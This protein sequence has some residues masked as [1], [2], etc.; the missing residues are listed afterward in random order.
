ME[1]Q[2]K[3]VLTILASVEAQ[4]K[5]IYG[6]TYKQAV[7]ISDVRKAIESGDATFSWSRNPGA[8]KKLETL[9]S[10]M[11][12]K[13]RTLIAKA[14][15]EAEQK[16]E[17]AA[18]GQL[19][20]AF[21]N[22]DDIKEL[23]REAIDL[24]RTVASA[25]RTGLNKSRGGFSPSSNVW[26][27]DEQSRKE[28]EAIIQKGIMEGKSADEVSRSI[29]QYLNEPDKLFRRVRDPE[30]GE[31]RL[32]KAASEYHPGP[33][34]YRSAYK[35]AMRLAR[36]E[37]TAAYRQS[38]W[39]SW[40]NNPLVVGIEIRLSNN[41]T[42]EDSKTGER[43]T[44]YDVCDEL[45][46]VYPKT[47]RWTGWH[48]QCRCDLYPVLV[49]K[50]DVKDIIKKRREARHAGKDPKE[51]LKDWHSKREVDNMPD[52]F[53]DWIRRN[54]DRLAQHVA[55]GKTPPYWVTD[56]FNSADIMRGLAKKLVQ[57]AAAAQPG[58]VPDE[59]KQDLEA[60]AKKIGVEV[61]EPMTFEEADELR[62]NPNY[63]SGGGYRVNC[64]SCVV[65]NELRRRGLDVEAQRNTKRS[66]NIPYELS[67]KTEWAWIDPKTGGRPTKTTCHATPDGQRTGQRTV[68]NLIKNVEEA[69]KNPGRY[70]LDWVWRG[71][72]SG[73]IITA[74]RLT[75]GTLRFYDPQ[76]GKLF[77]FRN[78]AS[79][80]DLYEG[81][82][83]L[84]VDNLKI[85]TSI[86][87]GVV[88]KSGKTKPTVKRMKSPEDIKFNLFLKSYKRMM[89]WYS[90]EDKVFDYWRKQGISDEFIAEF[91]E[92]LA[93][94]SSRTRRG[95]VSGDII[96]E[97]KQ[98][99]AEVLK[100]SR[101]KI[102]GKITY[103]N[104]AFGGKVAIFSRN[105]VTENLRLGPLFYVKTEILSEIESYLTPELKFKF[106][107]ST[108]GNNLGFYKARTEYKGR[109]EEF[110]GHTVELQFAIRPNK[111]LEFYFIKLL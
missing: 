101:E 75:D 29:R 51:A 81:V 93:S 89:T 88:A 40:Q 13:S 32:S 99:S 71:R 4:L 26:K 67:Y 64:Q 36:T 16:A 76:T 103:T 23:C 54:S 86:I 111:I 100:M 2:T 87:D 14:M 90:D 52:N 96:A 107:E 106:E 85:N 43:K 72:R 95:G 7:E 22:G 53:N 50:A 55:N 80:L 91:K 73:H 47:F 110:K 61:G 35:N 92:Y 25:S 9:L 37:I 56:N 12:T 57:A 1:Q 41:H 62:G 82:N 66:G 65:A 48:P 94:K 15:T 39:E 27:S 46:G 105:S 59:L 98:S 11:S 60:A 24:K 3:D 8:E 97:Q 10:K 109:I 5:K 79:E 17:T 102:I 6:D 42:V 83:V 30:T 70:H 68:E 34:V 84:R 20:M 28:L 104:P 21:G 78:R 31:Y 38:M 69:M 19:E 74:E 63:S 45:A 18:T 44:L 33:G 108:H 58:T 49:S 77:D